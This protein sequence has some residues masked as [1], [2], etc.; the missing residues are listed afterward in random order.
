MFWYEKLYSI[1]LTENLSINSCHN[2]LKHCY[3]HYISVQQN[4]VQLGSV[5]EI[6]VIQGGWKTPLHY[7]K[8]KNERGAWYLDQMIGLFVTD[9]IKREWLTSTLNEKAVCMIFVMFESDT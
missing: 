3:P 9:G 2:V 8:F 6:L 7:Q 4:G 1:Q 5:V